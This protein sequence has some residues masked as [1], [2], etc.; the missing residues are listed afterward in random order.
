MI[1]KAN[2][3]IKSMD[4]EIALLEAPA[5]DGELNFLLNTLKKKKKEK[6]ILY[7]EGNKQN[8]EKKR[9]KKLADDFNMSFLKP[10]LKLI[11]MLMKYLIS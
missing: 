3:L 9:R 10:L 4:D 6:E 7:E 2:E 11:K 8:N 5:I 1:D